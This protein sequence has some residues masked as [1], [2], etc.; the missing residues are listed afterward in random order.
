MTLKQD[1]LGKYVK[2]IGSFAFKSEDFLE[3]GIPILR[4]S[5]IQGGTVSIE[6]AA[7]ISESVIGKGV[8][9]SVESGDILIA[10]SGATTGKI[11]LVPQ[12]IEG[13][14]LQNQRVGNFKI[15]QSEKIDKGYLKHVVISPE[16]Q[17]QIFSSM[18]GAAQ[19]N[20]SSNQLENIKIPLPPLPQQRRIAA[21]LDQAD[22]LR[23]K[24]REALAQLD[25]LTQSIFIEMFGDPVTNPKNIMKRTLGELLTH[26]ERL[27]IPKIMI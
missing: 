5:D 3:N 8:K 13:L 18:A 23:A 24:R 2:V 9:Y 17:R 16:Y 21:I 26:I 10:M 27:T 25:K 15:L 1:L 7:R 4:I 12:N 14:V 22:A 11:G 6:K 19:P 20:I